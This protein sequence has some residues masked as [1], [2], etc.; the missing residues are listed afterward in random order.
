MGYHMLIWCGGYHRL[1]CPNCKERQ[2]YRIKGSDGP[3]SQN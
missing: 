2:A 3:V 1:I